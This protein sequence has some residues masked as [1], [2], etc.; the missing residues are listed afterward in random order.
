MKR[1]IVFDFDGVI[2]SYISGWKGA[3]NIPDK[4]VEGIKEAISEIRK[5]GYEVAVVSSR[6]A[7]KEGKN[8]I[9][10]YLENN[11]IKVDT[12]TSQKLPAICYIDD[13][14][15][16]FQGDPSSLLRQIRSFRPW[17]KR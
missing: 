6:A 16:C 13:R 4:P 7:S 9:E 12:V 15:I 10:H 14:A 3:E 1:T 5:S 8:A 2:H 11:G 17:N